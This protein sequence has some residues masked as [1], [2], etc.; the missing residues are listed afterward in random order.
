MTE[1]VQTGIYGLDE[2]MGGGFPKN[3]IALILG[4]PGAG[5]TILASQFLYKGL[6]EFNENGITTLNVQGSDI[7]AVI[8][9]ESGILCK[10]INNI[11][12]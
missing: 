6:T 7:E 4:G 9:N 8:A 1:T 3:R 2:M 12:N 5:K 11:M 10:I